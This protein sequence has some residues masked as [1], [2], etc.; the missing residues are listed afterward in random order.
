MTGLMTF[1][2]YHTVRAL[3]VSTVFVYIIAYV[4]PCPIYIP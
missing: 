2:F 3:K 1:S 4:A